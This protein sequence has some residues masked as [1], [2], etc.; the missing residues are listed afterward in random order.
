MFQ[1]VNLRKKGHL[2]SKTFNNEP[3]QIEKA[4]F[5]PCSLTE[6]FVKLLLILKTPYKKKDKLYLKLSWLKEL[7]KKEDDEDCVKRINSYI[8]SLDLPLVQADQFP[9]IDTRLHKTSF[10]SNLFFENDK[11]LSAEGVYLK[12]ASEIEVIFYERVTSYT[13]T[14]DSTFVLKDNS[15]ETHSCVDRKKMNILSNWAKTNKIAFYETGPDP[16]CWKLIMKQ[17]KEKSW[18]DIHDLLTAQVSSEEEGSEWEAGLTEEEASD[19]DFDEEDYPD[20]ISEEE[21]EF[22][23]NSDFESSSEDEEYYNRSTGNK[24]RVLYDSDDSEEE[25]IPTKKLRH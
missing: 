16:L 20:E 11:C 19:D 8:K 5:F 12:H 18:K 14:F 17:R 25:Y 9:S 10:M 22:T 3:I 1:C 6:E 7:K 13:K 4:Y 24:K 21:E 15:I 23:D 2:S